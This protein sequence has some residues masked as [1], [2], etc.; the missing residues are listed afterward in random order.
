M[1]RLIVDIMYT[2]TLNIQTRKTSLLAQYY[3]KQ[4]FR[5]VRERPV[6]NFTLGRLRDW[7]LIT[8]YRE[9]LNKFRLIHLKSR[10]IF[11][12]AFL[13]SKIAFKRNKFNFF[14]FLTRRVSFQL[15]SHGGNYIKLRTK[16]S[17]C[18]FYFLKFISR[19]RT[20]IRHFQF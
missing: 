10:G 5:C 7:T 20:Y 14:F 4:D 1:T 6:L 12:V 13:F 9:I 17:E 8:L 15:I 18:D 19:R 2:S 16:Y 3:V 11:P